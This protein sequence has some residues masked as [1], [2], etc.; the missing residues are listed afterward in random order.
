LDYSISFWECVFNFYIIFR[1]DC[2]TLLNCDPFFNSLFI[3]IKFNGK[4]VFIHKEAK[5]YKLTEI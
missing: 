4:D 2:S 1:S 5:E 3:I